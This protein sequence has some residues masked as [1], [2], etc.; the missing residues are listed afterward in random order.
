MF[1]SSKQDKIAI[2]CFLILVESEQRTN[3]LSTLSENSH[4]KEVKSDGLSVSTSQH[5]GDKQNKVTYRSLLRN[6]P[7]DL[8]CSP[9]YPARLCSSGTE[10]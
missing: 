3:S 7:D 8:P 4:Y 9:S 2:L 5:P 1:S 10:A 6:L